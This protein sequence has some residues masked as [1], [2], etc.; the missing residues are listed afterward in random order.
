MNAL[1]NTKSQLAKLM[2]SENITVQHQKAETA[3][4]DVKNRV[5]TLPI[6]E[7]GMSNDVY[8]LMVSHEVGHALWTPEDGW[9]DSVCA[10]GPMYKGFLNIIEDARIERKIRNKFPGLAGSYRKGYAELLEK[11]FFGL[12]GKDITEFAFIDRINLYFKTGTLTGLRFEGEELN[13]IKRI[14]GA[15][16]FEEVKAIADELFAAE[17]QKAEE[18]A[19]EMEAN[20]EFDEPEWDDLE[21]DFDDWSDG[22]GDETEEDG[23]EETE[24][25]A[26]GSEEGDTE[27]TEEK[28]TAQAGSASDVQ[29]GETKEAEQNTIQSGAANEMPADKEEAIKEMLGGDT[30]RNLH[31]NMHTLNAENAKEYVYKTLPASIKNFGDFI[32]GYKEVLAEFK[33]NEIRLD[34]Y[35][36]A[37]VSEKTKLFR[38]NNMSVINL[39]AKEFE[40]RKKADEYKRTHVAKSGELDMNKIFGY[41]FNDDL[42]LRNTVVK[43]GKNHGFVMYVDWSG[44][45][46]NQMSGTIDQ[47]LTLVMFCRKVRIP[48]EVFSFTDGWG[49]GA[50]V[51]NASDYKVGD[52]VPERFNLVQLFSTN[53]S[54]SDFNA[55]IENMV[56]VRESLAN[57]RYYSLPL[58]D[59]M[60]LAT[61]PLNSALTMSTDVIETFKKKYRVQICNFVVLTDGDS[62]ACGEVKM[63][64]YDN[65]IRIGHSYDRSY[66]TTQT[67]LTDSVTKKS[68]PMK[69]NMTECLL[70]AIK[71]RTG[72]N[73]IGI[74][75]IENK[76]GNIR[77]AMASYGIWSVDVK[78][79][80]KNKFA[81]VTSAGYDTYFLMPGGDLNIGEE[82]LDVDAGASKAR[83]KSAFLKHT[84]GKTE[85]RVFVS[86]L[87]EIAA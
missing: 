56:L 22:M 58:P 81:A 36:I 43:D 34:Q 38:K 3:S 17:K 76:P 44:S 20:G 79:F 35:D 21:E 74:Y 32:V 73:T 51:E 69:R 15:D 42:F 55:Q 61:T 46:V 23:E 52:L 70:K 26:S 80:R 57:K 19:E 50:A 62:H 86:K 16:T 4:F 27:E 49:R 83:L 59:K 75:L 47:L 5:L 65:E 71:E 24:T 18:K 67:V 39:M 25:S 41:K 28:E 78:E 29:D 72:C 40:M 10:N 30:E 37:Q 12:A 68:Y 82:T 13:W 87:M 8:D 64:E 6:F 53:M 48:F 7:D 33:E 85:N 77:S 11:D 63:D 66:R 60:H 31:K 2:A 14:A 54:V 9:H 84:K 45:M 1:A